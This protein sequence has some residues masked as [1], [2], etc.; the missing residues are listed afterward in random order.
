[1]FVGQGER[2]ISQG[3]TTIPHGEWRERLCQLGAADFRFLKKLFSGIFGKD[4]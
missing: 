2:D 1:M 4:I 3:T